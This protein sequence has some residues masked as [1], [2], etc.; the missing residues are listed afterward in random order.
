MV[1]WISSGGLSS[2]PIPEALKARVM[3]PHLDGDFS[4]FHLTVLLE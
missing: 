2:I 1:Y 4:L 3:L